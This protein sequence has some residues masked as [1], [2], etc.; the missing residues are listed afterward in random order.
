MSARF[1]YRHPASTA[2]AIRG[3][4]SGTMYSVVCTIV[5]ADDPAIAWPRDRSIAPL[6]HLQPH[7][8]I[9]DH[10]NPRYPSSRV[11]TRVRRAN[12]PQRGSGAGRN[13]PQVKSGSPSFSVHRQSRAAVASCPQRTRGS[14]APL[15]SSAQMSV[16]RL[17][18]QGPRVRPT[19]SVY[20]I[21]CT[22]YRVQRHTKYGV[23]VGKLEA[24][25]S[26]RDLTA[27]PVPCAGGSYRV[28][29]TQ[30]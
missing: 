10:R 3:S 13:Q 6:Y 23:R 4:D 28:V 7:L 16:S 14:L 15:T 30:L 18:D 19:Y 22:E 11:S 8:D 17:G 2:M 26:A 20:T 24:G 1:Y 25:D 27:S 29:H 21:R 9:A 5:G 12:L